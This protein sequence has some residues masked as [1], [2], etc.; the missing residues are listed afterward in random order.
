MPTPFTHL[1]IAQR[2]LQDDVLSDVNALL[3]A[4]RSAFLLGSV[5]ADARVE[6]G[7]SRETTHFYAYDQP[8][9]EH[10]WRVMLRLHPQLQAAHS[11]AQRAFLAGYAA[12]LSVDEYWTVNLVRPYFVKRDWGEFTPAFRFMMLHI[13]LSYMDERDL[14]RLYSWQYETLCD[15]QPQDWLPFMSDA[16]LTG[17]RNYIGEQIKPSGNSLTLSVFGARISKTPEELRAI[18]DS[19][20]QMQ[21]GLWANVPQD[22]LARIEG[23]MYAFAREQMV[24]FLDEYPADGHI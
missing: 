13:I 19:P 8:I 18:L 17:W 20:E 7:A 22:D 4:E 11:P 1:E 16:T 15:A 10:P 23:E 9:G 2:L 5:A 3:N 21:R 14:P 12:H 24:I 6:S